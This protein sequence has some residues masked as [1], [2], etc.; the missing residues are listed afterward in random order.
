MTEALL[1]HVR[2][3]DDF[4]QPGIRFFDLNPIYA[5]PELFDALVEELRASL[6]RLI[7]VSAVDYVVGPDARGFIAGTRLA[8]ALGCGFLAT[9]KPSKLPPP[10]SSVSYG[11]EYGESILELSAHMPLAGAKVIVHDDVLATGGTAAASA[12]LLARAGAEVVAFS[13]SLEVAALSGSDN[14]PS[15]VPVA[16]VL[17]S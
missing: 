1:E 6:D 13:F 12:E 17:S 10:V 8:A 9:R 7:D 11:L 5:R 14:L 3:V 4:P 16:I 2:E 15:G